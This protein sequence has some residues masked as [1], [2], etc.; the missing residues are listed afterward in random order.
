MNKTGI[1]CF[2]TESELGPAGLPDG[3]LFLHSKE[4][5]ALDKLC[6][7]VMRLFEK[8]NFEKVSPPLFEYYETFEKG[9][10]I[11]IA[12]KTFSFKDKDG[13]LLSLRYDMTTPIARMAARHYEKA[14]LPLK[15]YYCEDVLREQ[16][17]HK[18]KLRQMKQAGVELI[19]S[20]GIKSDAEII[21]LLGKSLALFDR[22]Y[23]IIMGDVRLYQYIISKFNMSALTLEA[24]H[25]LL[26]RKDCVSLKEIIKNIDGLDQYK[27]ALYELPFTAGIRDD[28]HHKIKEMG[29]EYQP[30]CE[31][32]FSLCDS[33]P[34]ELKSHIIIDLALIKDFS[35]YT[36]LTLEGYIKDSGFPAANGGRY[37]RLFSAFGKDCPAVGF[38]LDIGSYHYSL[39]YK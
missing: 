8:E 37:D 25:Q 9:G 5:R 24:V 13:K 11:D 39:N 16:P 12:R 20:G 26:N 1:E 21:G 23:K 4:L 28:V 33:L 19:G 3:V 32:L 14:K 7:K 34:G 30:Y 6:S 31:R 27:K 36:S 38:A 18:G 15:F 10:G 29:K 17:L 35:Y 2:F 22:G